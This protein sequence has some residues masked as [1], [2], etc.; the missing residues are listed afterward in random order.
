M[1]LKNYNIL[2]IIL[3]HPVLKAVLSPYLGIND[4]FAAGGTEAGGDVV[5]EQRVPR[6]CDPA[7]AGQAVKEGQLLSVLPPDH[8][9]AAVAADLAFPQ[10]AIAI[11]ANHEDPSFITESAYAWLQPHAMDTPREIR[12]RGGT[13]ALKASNDNRIKERKKRKIFPKPPFQAFSGKKS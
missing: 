4:H 2:S 8:A 6:G 13:V 12:F 11:G 1:P 5:M 7:D 3:Q 9:A 10:F